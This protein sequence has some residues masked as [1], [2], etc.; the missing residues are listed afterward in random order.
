MVF[1]CS[2]PC[3]P[4]WNR[5][6]Q[7]TQEPHGEATAVSGLHQ[8]PA[9]PAEAVVEPPAGQQSASKLC[10]GCGTTFVRAASAQK[11]CSPGCRLRLRNKVA[12][13][14]KRAREDAAW[15]VQTDRLR[16]LHAAEGYLNGEAGN[17]TGEERYAL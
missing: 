5:R 4:L 13:E 17:A 16:E 7:T 9:E 3:L 12:Y 15:R 6:F 11:F 14:R 10:P 8:V 2:W 1:E